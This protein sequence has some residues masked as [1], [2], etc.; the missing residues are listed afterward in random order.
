MFTFGEIPS[1]GE[2]VPFEG[3]LSSDR[4]ALT[5]TFSTGASAEL[6]ERPGALAT[7]AFAVVLPLEGAGGRA[8]IEFALSAG[9][10]LTE[11]STATVV[12]TVNGQTA[13]ADFVS[14]PH[15][16]V[17]LPLTFVAVDPSECRVFAELVA[18]RDSQQPNAAAHLNFIALDAEIPLPAATVG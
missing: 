8:K 11:K 14:D 2:E 9:V 13:V 7:R 4:R 15:Q 16:I 6:D 5:L 1:S 18:G 3:S 12:L 17:V 10:V